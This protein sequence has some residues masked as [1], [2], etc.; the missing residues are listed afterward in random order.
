MVE[1]VLH[2]W[3]QECRYAPEFL[4][5]QVWNLFLICKVNVRLQRPYIHDLD[6]GSQPILQLK[7]QAVSVPPEAPFPG[8]LVLKSLQW[9]VV[10]DYDSSLQGGQLNGVFRLWYWWSMALEIGNHSRGRHDSRNTAHDLKIIYRKQIQKVHARLRYH[11]FF[12]RKRKGI[13]QGPYQDLRT[14]TGTPTW[15]RTKAK[16]S[17]L[18]D[19]SWFDDSGIFV[20]KRVRN[21]EGMG[22][23]DGETVAICDDSLYLALSLSNLQG[24]KTEMHGEGR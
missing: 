8:L 22:T 23:Q 3:R 13:D 11:S 19:F 14:R 5:Q 21:E 15:E 1:L 4:E 16:W 20:Y 12:G 2:I 7:R 17:A 18:F 10:C 24:K 9:K 6:I